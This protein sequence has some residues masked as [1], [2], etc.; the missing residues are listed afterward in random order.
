MFLAYF[1]WDPSPFVFSYTLPLLH[2]PL[3]WYGLF[4]AL[5]F[6]LGYL[7]MIHCIKKRLK[8]DPCF[9][10]KQICNWRVLREKLDRAKANPIDPLHRVARQLKS[11]AT[12]QE[13]CDALIHTYDRSTLQTLLPKIVMSL[14]D[15]AFTFVDKGCWFVVLG[16]LIGARLGHVFFYGWDYYRTH[17]AEI[18]KLWEGGL[19]SHGGGLGVLFAIYLFNK[20]VGKKIIPNLT[21]VSLLD[22]LAIPTALTAFFIRLGNFFNQEIVGTVTDVPW[23]V[24]FGHPWEGGGALPRHPVQMYEG[25]LYLFLFFVLYAMWKKGL[26]H[27]QEG[28]ITGLFFLVVFSWRLLMEFLKAPQGGVFENSFLQTGQMLSLPFIAVGL[29]LTLRSLSRRG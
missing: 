22:L 27:R 26:Q 2:R 13:I 25:L 7:I 18:P 29:W 24:R 17:L 5:G 12:Q 14:N 4:F 20:W 16:A 15:V 21:F 11:D 9:T 10:P 28:V 1:D 19:A 8:V 23:A 3:G 6:L